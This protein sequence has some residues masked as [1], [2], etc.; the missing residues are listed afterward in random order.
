MA[1]ISKENAQKYYKELLRNYNLDTDLANIVP[2][3]KKDLER[4]I[5]FEVTGINFFRNTMNYDTKEIIKL[6]QS[7]W[8]RQNQKGIDENR[9]PKGFIPDTLVRDIEQIW[10]WRN[11]AEHEKNMPKVVLN[12]LFYT[13]ARCIS[14]F[15][16]TDF[17]EEINEIL[18]PALAK[19]KKKDTPIQNPRKQTSQ[20]P[21]C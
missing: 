6:G 2:I 14:F 8:L 20:S 3:F 21:V 13:M 19:Q 15:S 7:G 4:E 1:N 17:P 10:Y 18:N 9:K 12:H 16:E 5:L 11:E